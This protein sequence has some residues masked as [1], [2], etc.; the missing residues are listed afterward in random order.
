MNYI[1][2]QFKNTH[3]G[4]RCFIVGNGPSLK[5]SDLDLIKNERSFAMNRVSLIY[6][7]TDW[8]PDY[9]VCPTGN[10]VRQDWAINIKETVSTGIP[11]WFWDTPQNKIIYKDFPNVIYSKF[12]G[13]HESANPLKD[14]PIEWFSYNPEQWLSKYGTSLIAAAQLA[15][16]MGFVD[17]Y[18]LGCDLGFGLK[19]HHFDP[20][21]NLGGHM[22][23]NK[24]DD[25][26]TSAHV[27]IRKASLECG[28]NV[29][30][31]TRGGYLEVYPRISLEEVLNNE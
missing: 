2:K 25:T 9:F 11:C 3:K 23:R 19:D 12:R 4:E 6:D 28:I 22:A 7:K 21:Y 30:N 18:M 1:T 13:H 24:L 8:R 10:S 27:L 29:Y 16:Y 20:K 26:M 14:P 15:F 5:G 31:A 17:I